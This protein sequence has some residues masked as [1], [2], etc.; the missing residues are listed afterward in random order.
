MQAPRR[1]LGLLVSLVQRHGDL[2]LSAYRVNSAK[3]LSPA[4]RQ[5]ASAAPS[6]EYVWVAWQDGERIWFYTAALSLELSRER[7]RPILE[8]WLYNERAELHEASTWLRNADESW[9]QCGCW[10]TRT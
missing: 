2:P 6:G 10:L 5:M 8:L 9:R 4:L 7:G 1:A 3:E